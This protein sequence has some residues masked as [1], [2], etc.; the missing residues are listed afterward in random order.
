MR[1]LSMRHSKRKFRASFGKMKA[2]NGASI[3]MR[4]GVRL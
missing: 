4:G 3:A 2:I 1:R